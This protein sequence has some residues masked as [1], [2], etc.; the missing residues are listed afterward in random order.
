MKPSRPVAALIAAFLLTSTPVPAAA[1][2]AETY[3][4]GSSKSTVRLRRAADGKLFLTAL[5]AGRP[6]TLLVDTGASMLLDTGV[7]QRLGLQLTDTDDV[8]YGLT[9]ITAPRKAT[10]IDMKLGGLT[11][12][13]LP[14]SCLDLTPLRDLHR[15]KSMPILDGV[16][17]SELMAVLRA[18]IDFDALTLEIRRPDRRSIA[19]ELRRRAQP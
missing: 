8:G 6:V 4:S 11:I 15:E 16:I 9:G 17:G 13:G 7:A 2:E 19:E 3:Y 18:R 5:I 1:Q 14:A 12:T 10:V